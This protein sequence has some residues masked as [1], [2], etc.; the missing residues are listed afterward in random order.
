MVQG[1]LHRGTKR[2]LLRLKPFIFKSRL[3]EQLTSHIFKPTTEEYTSKTCTNCGVI[4]D[5][6][7]GNSVYK[8]N[9][10]KM[11]LDR[12]INGARNIYIKDTCCN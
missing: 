1:T 9:N 8:C 11:T 2:E 10:C 6:L 7:N 12:D 5:D 3:K 4:K